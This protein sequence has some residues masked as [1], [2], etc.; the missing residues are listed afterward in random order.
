MCTAIT[1]S[2]LLIIVA[3]NLV[4]K[5][6]ME[7]LIHKVLRNLHQ[8]KLRLWLILKLT[9]ALIVM[10]YFTIPANKTT[11]NLSVMSK[12]TW[13][14]CNG[15]SWSWISY[16]ILWWILVKLIMRLTS[17]RVWIQ[18]GQINRTA[19]GTI[20]EHMQCCISCEWSWEV[21]QTDDWG[22][23]TRCI[24]SIRVWF[25][26][27]VFKFSGCVLLTRL[28]TVYLHAALHGGIPPMHPLIDT[29]TASNSMADS[30]A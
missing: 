25:Y 5:P 28:P 29:A 11:E 9:D 30:V 21:A 2:E 20:T 19:V 16:W 10:R 24:F 12:K 13:N 14:E 7:M 15:N 22:S 23:K 1:N 3:W 6:C 26:E 27:V 18:Q 17:I 4:A 8:I